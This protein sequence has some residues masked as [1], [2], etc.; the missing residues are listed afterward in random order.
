METEIRVIEP[1]EL[2]VRQLDGQA[3]IIAGYGVVFNSW[4]EVMTDSRG[5]KFRERVVSTTFDRVLKSG[6]DI[7]ALWS[8]DRSKPLG[9]LRNG[10][11]RLTKDARGIRL[12]IDPPPTT[13][14]TDAVESIRRGDVAGMS[15]AFVINDANGDTWSRGGPDG[16][17]ERT[18]LD[19][20]LLEFSPVTEP[21]Y[22]ATSVS[23][24]SVNVPDF[25]DES[26]SRA[27]DEIQAAGD[28]RAVVAGLL[29]QQ[30]EILRRR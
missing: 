11:L 1:E 25:S 29:Q 3:P 12:E 30:I 24:R 9:R 27:A 16:I 21:A 6:V 7:R 14:G 22:P 19:A 10:T 13:W 8:H 23:V 15:F 5:R 2:E 28:N 18:L 26:D 4:S 20:D 17:A